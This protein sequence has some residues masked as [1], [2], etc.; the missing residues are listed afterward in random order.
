MG[1]GQTVTL[2]E[3]MGKRG[4]DFTKNG[5]ELD[6]LPHLLGEAMPKLEFH[7]LGR[8]RLMRALRQRF[9]DSYRNVP[10]ISHVIQKFDEQA[11]IEM[12]HHELKKKFAPRRK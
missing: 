3:L 2:N 8:V 9:G 5:V 11:R 6:E 4:E 10:G 7:A 1:K 12:K